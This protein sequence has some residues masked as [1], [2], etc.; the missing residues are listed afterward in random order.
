MLTQGEI[1]AALAVGHEV[2]GFEFKG[3]GSPEDKPFLAK[4]VRGALS[5]G[6]LRD[7][8][9]VVIGID[10][11]AP[12]DMLPG[13]AES[14]LE[15]WLDFDTIS[16]RLAEYAD[17]PLRVEI[18]SVTL[19]T[20][21]SVVLIEVEEFA[22]VPHLCAKSFEPALRKGALY[23]RTHRIP[24]TAE[25]PTQTEMREVIELAT[26]KRLRAYVQTAQ[27]AGVTLSADAE[28]RQRETQESSERFEAQL[29]E[30]W[31]E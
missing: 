4:V 1:E 17:P 2:R 9:I 30:A 31:D 20:G 21:A 7:G 29:G 6:N 27:R 25:V 18:H 10:D 8:G 13:L 15:A 22:E 19:M 12:A 26:E 16:A 3:P 11:K 28:A 5:M 23:V 24:E 14:D